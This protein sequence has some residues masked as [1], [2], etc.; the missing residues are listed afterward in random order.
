MRHGNPLSS[1][2]VECFMGLRGE[3]REKAIATGNYDEL[4][5]AQEREPAPEPQRERRGAFDMI[6]EDV[7][8]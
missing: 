7:P 3:A 6:D 5:K 4:V 8:I 1:A 2:V